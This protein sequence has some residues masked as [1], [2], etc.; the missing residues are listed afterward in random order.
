[1]SE[2]ILSKPQQTYFGKARLS[3]PDARHIFYCEPETLH[4]DLKQ[5]Q[6]ILSVL[7][8]Y[9][10]GL[11][12]HHGII[13]VNF[14]IVKEHFAFRGIDIDCITVFIPNAV[15]RLP[16]VEFAKS[17]QSFFAEHTISSKD[18]LR[19][20]SIEIVC[21]YT[22]YNELL[23]QTIEFFYANGATDFFICSR[24]GKQDFLLIKKGCGVEER[25]E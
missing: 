21:D 7:G 6:H 19:D 14:G 12:T 1:M 11:S 5:K 3:P 15:R 9:K 25:I 10:F 8:Y 13:P 2:G 16:D 24:H 4:S 23:I 18:A 22:S 17:L 20:K